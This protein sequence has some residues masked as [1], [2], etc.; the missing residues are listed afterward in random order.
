MSNDDYNFLPPC[1]SSGMAMPYSF[2]TITTTGTGTGRVP[3]VSVGSSANLDMYD[4]IGRGRMLMQIS[5]EVKLLEDRLIFYTKEYEEIRS[6]IKNIRAILGMPR[7]PEGQDMKMSL[8]L[9][10]LAL[11]LD[12]RADVFGNIDPMIKL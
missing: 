5:N 6:Q 9:K 4:H 10:E 8:A 11:E 2:R 7:Q 1:T 12:K 3:Q